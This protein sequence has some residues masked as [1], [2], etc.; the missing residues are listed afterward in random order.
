M[1]ENTTQAIDIWNLGEAEYTKIKLKEIEEKKKSIDKSH[2]LIVLA[3]LLVS[4]LAFINLM[5]L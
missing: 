2:R 4:L 5:V 3:P 1:K